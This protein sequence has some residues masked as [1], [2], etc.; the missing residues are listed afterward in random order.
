[1]LESNEHTMMN[2]NVN[3]SHP[4][5][6]NSRPICDNYHHPVITL[7]NLQNMPYQTQNMPYCYNQ[8]V[9]QTGAAMVY[10]Q[11]ENSRM[12]F[13]RKTSG[14]PVYENPYGYQFT[15]S[16]SNFPAHENHHLQLK[17][18]PVCPWPLQPNGVY[19]Y[20]DEAL[21]SIGEEH[22]RN[23]RIRHNSAPQADLNPVWQSSSQLFHSSSS[24]S[25]APVVGGTSLPGAY[26]QRNYPTS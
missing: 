17:P 25:S 11:T 12:A 19:R 13:K 18:M 10:P 5:T 4:N 15:G 9:N 26:S 21:F 14:R 16:S 20:P 7:G 2:Y 24:I 1:M 6:L 8:R 22:Q 3:F 23:V